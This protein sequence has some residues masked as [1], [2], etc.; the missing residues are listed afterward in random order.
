[1]N[2]GKKTVRRKGKKQII[3]LN[4][5]NKSEISTK[6][7]AVPY[8]LLFTKISPYLKV[9][10][11]LGW[12]NNT[13]HLTDSKYTTV[14]EGSCKAREEGRMKENRLRVYRP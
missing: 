6:L 5:E 3:G 14:I 1:M 10:Q 13:S 9:P 11:D 7:Q 12:E 2:Y 4:H 8:K